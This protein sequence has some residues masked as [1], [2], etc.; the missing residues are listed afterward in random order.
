MKR[1]IL[2]IVIGWLA[3]FS[4]ALS[5]DLRASLQVK[6]LFCEQCPLFIHAHLL[7]LD[8]VKNVNVVVIGPDVA[9]VDVSFDPTKVTLDGVVA[10]INSGGFTVRY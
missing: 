6:G 3:C 10:R 4:I 9:M 8:G 7:G 2:A 1:V 5:G